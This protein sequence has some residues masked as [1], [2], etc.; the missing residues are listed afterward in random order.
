MK[1]AAHRRQN[2]LHWMIIGAVLTL[3][4]VFLNQNASFLSASL[5]PLRSH[6][7]FDGLV[8]P[9]KYVPNWSS[10][11][12]DERKLGYDQLPGSKFI[13]LPVY[14]PSELTVPFNDLLFGNPEHN[15]LRNA[16]ITFSVP[17]LG[18]YR[19]DGKEEVGSH[20]AV[21]IK[22]PMNTP[23]LAIGN[24]VVVKASDGDA[25]FGKVIVIKHLNFP[26]LEDP[27][28]QQEIYSGYGHLGRIDVTVG[29]LVEKG[30]IIGLSGN[31]GFA[32]TPHV[33]FQIDNNKAPW[34]P[35]WPFTYKEAAN[36]GYD[37]VGAINAGLG[38]E[39]AREM[40]FNP[41]L[42]VQLYQNEQAPIAV[43]ETPTVEIPPVEN[44]P[45]ENAT[46]PPVVTKAAE[47]VPPSSTPEPSP[48]IVTITPTVTPE[49]QVSPAAPTPSPLSEQKISSPVKTETTPSP[50]PALN[51]AN[52]D[53]I[54]TASTLNKFDISINEFTLLETNFTAY[55]SAQNEAGNILSSENLG[56]GVRV[57][58]ENRNI[59]DT[60]RADLSASDFDQG[61]APVVV[62]PKNT[63]ETRLVLEHNGQKY[64]SASFRVIAKINP[65]TKIKIEHDGR[66][67]PGSPE[68][69]TLVLYDENG[70]PTP[71]TPLG[72]V[73]MVA[74]RAE[75]IFSSNNF[76]F[77]NF[78][79]GRYEINF[80][81]TGNQ[82]LEIKARGG[83]IYGSTEIF[84][85]DAVF[86]D[87]RSHQA[88]Y[89]AIKYLKERKILSG[90]SDGTFQPTKVISR[91]EL[92]KI[93][94]SAFAIPHRSDET[95][96]FR[97]VEPQSWF[98]PY[99]FTAAA[100]Q[101][102]DGYPDK[103]FRPNQKMNRAEFLKVLLRAAEINV[104]AVVS[105]KP[106]NDV[107]I[108]QWFAVYAQY[109]K[110]TDIFPVTGNDFEGEKSLTRGEAA[111]AIY[112]LQKMREKGGERF[113][114]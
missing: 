93:L 84:A 66:Y 23:I 46:Q 76:S 98:A 73:E 9:V 24:G 2:Y 38:L 15:A 105:A 36:A 51:T 71:E 78:Q 110:K 25:G 54:K 72:S 52:S 65:A 50:Y 99:V 67:T 39:R 42:Y 80:R 64:Y 61:V 89:E 49:P 48:E 5:L 26:T 97:D 57:S 69:I 44:P 56:K 94:I 7:P 1:K 92:L 14:Q 101:I 108:D 104:D 58:V 75:V 18:N 87:V 34:H 35:Y 12:A 17:Y 29:D 37:F 112:R 63:G 102:V 68:K 77:S 82:D 27:V 91:A 103:S 6:K 70:N 30:Q 4:M 45:V 114:G 19:L 22:I 95:L 90:Y 41:M 40:T 28:P 109:A 62:I 21:D 32:T 81:A 43:P 83:A 10:L 79:N 100:L 8:P 33:H 13:K 20:P 106:Y 111:E 31:S 74:S 11:T 53:A 107:D 47:P 55:V 59:A 88:N 96:F 3:I 85:D 60:S 86:S 16:K 113:E